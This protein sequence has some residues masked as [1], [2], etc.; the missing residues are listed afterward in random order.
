MYVLIFIDCLDK[1]HLKYDD[2]K[3][4]CK[5]SLGSLFNEHDF[6]ESI[7]YAIAEKQLEYKD[8]QLEITVEKRKEI[9]I[10]KEM[11][12]NGEDEAKSLYINVCK[13][14]GISEIDWG[15]FR[16]YFI[17]EISKFLS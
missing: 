8:D 12:Q 13:N 16:D 3:L 15:I 6:D 5:E 4:K 2:L 7:D 10:S 11:Q 1:G 17:I 9:S 14:L